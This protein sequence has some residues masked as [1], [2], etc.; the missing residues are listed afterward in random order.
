MTKI[1]TMPIPATI[2]TPPA[3]KDSTDGAPNL[4]DSTTTDTPS[5]S[6]E[7]ADNTPVAPS[8]TPAHP[9]NVT[10]KPPPVFY[11]P[12][13]WNIEIDNRGVVTAYNNMTGD[14]F[15]GSMRDFNQMMKGQ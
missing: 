9:A 2:G 3:N 10:N 12:A 11:M 13:H 5:P 7:T 15:E 8:L 6:P 4:V 1:H 14:K